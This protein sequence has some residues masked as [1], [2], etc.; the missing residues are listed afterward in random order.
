MAVQ[1]N[2]S[3]GLSIIVPAYRS[4]KTVM[5]SLASLTA[6]EGCGEVEVIVVDSSPDDATEAIVREHF[7][8]VVYE[9][10]RDRLLPHAARNRGAA[11]ARGDLILFTDP[12]IIAPPDWGRRMMDMQAGHNGVAVAAIACYGERWLDL[13]IH[14]CK[15][16]NWLPGG[17]VRKI[18]IGPTSGMLCSRAAFTRVGGFQGEYMLADTL[19]SEAFIAAGIPL[20]FMP[21]PAAAHWHTSGFGAFLRERAERGRE[22]GLLRLQ[23]GARGRWRTLAVLA[24]LPLRLVSQT[25]RTARHAIRGHQSREFLAALPVLV[26]GHAA[27]LFGEARTGLRRLLGLPQGGACKF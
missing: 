2:Q 1:V 3:I 19:I 18:G 8:G 27:W 12:D 15:Y 17:A 26:C 20:W 4:Q 24:L 10:V 7:P 25:A 13:G 22:Y 14:F 23:R 21:W 11:L 6:Q 16:G 9:H 5:S